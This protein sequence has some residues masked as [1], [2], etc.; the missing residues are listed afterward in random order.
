M[1]DQSNRSGDLIHDA[2]FIH[3]L[4]SFSHF[5]GSFSHFLYSFVTA[6]NPGMP[7]LGSTYEAHCSTY[8]L[9]HSLILYS[10]CMST[11]TSQRRRPRS[12][13]TNRTQ[14]AVSE[15]LDQWTSEESES[16]W[17]AMHGKATTIAPGERGEKS[18]MKSTY[19]H[20]RTETRTGIHRGTN[21][22][23][24]THAQVHEG[25]NSPRWI[26]NVNRKT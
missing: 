21:R 7:W 16:Q 25:E 13:H 14:Y 15:S 19:A 12:R 18:V 1:I 8:S 22:N 10:A 20:W 9:I 17:L 2:P 4:C 3:L 11:V 6:G 24:Q 5:L 23:I 26:Y